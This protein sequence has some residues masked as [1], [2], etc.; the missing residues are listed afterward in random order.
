MPKSKIIVNSIVYIMNQEDYNISERQK[1]P[2]QYIPKKF[3]IQLLKFI[4]K[5][6]QRKHAHDEGIYD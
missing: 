4:K 3:F 6:C 1:K 5:D 2:G